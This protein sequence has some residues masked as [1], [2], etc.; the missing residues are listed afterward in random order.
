MTHHVKYGTI[1][2]ERVAYQEACELSSLRIEIGS[3]NHTSFP[4]AP[5]LFESRL[6]NNQ[7]GTRATRG[8]LP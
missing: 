6:D 3:K 7:N 8:N 2:V 5:H 4:F 1:V